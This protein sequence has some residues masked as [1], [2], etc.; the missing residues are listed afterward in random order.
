MCVLPLGDVRS[1]QIFDLKSS[2]LSIKK[3][4]NGVQLQNIRNNSHAYKLFQ[5]HTLVH[6]YRIFLPDFCLT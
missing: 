3:E 5:L 4:T 6:K 2:L 1:C